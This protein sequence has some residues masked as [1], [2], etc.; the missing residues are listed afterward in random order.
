[1]SAHSLLVTAARG[2]LPLVEQELRVL[3]AKTV[4]PTPA[5]LRVRAPL[6]FAYRVC[7]WSRCASRVVAHVHDAAIDG[8]DALYE[9]ARAVAWEDHLGPD[10]TLAVDVVLHGDVVTHSR[11][12]AQRI[13]DGV[14]DRMRELHG[15]RPSVDLEAPAI[16]IHADVRGRGCSF[17]IDLSGEPLHR[18]GWRRAQGAAPLKETLAAGLLL[19]ADWP[20]RAAAGAPLFDPLCGAGTIAIEA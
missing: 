10:D 14:V 11:Y 16:R 15:R 13:K 8:S 17:G 3:G 19:R 20:A 4:R 18:R 6:E 7:M 5:G 9:A 12:A 2:L 1:M